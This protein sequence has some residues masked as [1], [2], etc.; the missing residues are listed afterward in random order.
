MYRTMKAYIP[1]N[2][3]QGS[4]AQGHCTHHSSHGRAPLIIAL[5]P[6]GNGIVDV[7]RVRPARRPRRGP[8]AVD[9]HAKRH[10]IADASSRRRVHDSSAATDPAA[11]TT[12]AREQFLCYCLPSPIDTDSTGTLYLGHCPYQRQGSHHSGSPAAADETAEAAFDVAHA[13]Q[14]HPN[15][16]LTKPLYSRLACS[17]PAIFPA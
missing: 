12:P 13:S 3:T 10:I 4:R 11:S 6:G 15:I 16:R 14:P 7:Y 17:R 9:L 8:C 2:N 5:L 1:K